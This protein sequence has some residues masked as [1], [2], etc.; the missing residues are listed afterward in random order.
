MDDQTEEEDAVE[1]ATRLLAE[2]DE[3][4]GTSKSEI[5]RSTSFCTAALDGSRLALVPSSESGA[6][7]QRTS[8]SGS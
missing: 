5:W 6:L 3:G 1:L 7:P 8:N 2:W 4:R